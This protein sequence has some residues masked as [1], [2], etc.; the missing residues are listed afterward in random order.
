MVHFYQNVMNKASGKEKGACLLPFLGVLFRC[1]F[2]SWG[3]PTCL[4][5]S[6]ADSL[7]LDWSLPNESPSDGD[8]LANQRKKLRLVWVCGLVWMYP[9]LWM[10]YQPPPTAVSAGSLGGGALG[11]G[12]VDIPSLRGGGLFD[13]HREG[14]RLLDHHDVILTV[15]PQV[16]LGE[17]KPLHSGSL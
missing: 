9:C 3:V 17:V 12:S 16:E 4:V 6:S 5:V 1:C 11:F 13:G 7:P 10:C 8:S 2:P 14:T 15:L